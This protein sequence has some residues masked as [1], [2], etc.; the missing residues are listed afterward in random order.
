MSQMSSSRR[1][2]HR[3]SRISLRVD[4]TTDGV[5][6][7][8]AEIEN[9]TLSA[10]M[11]DAAYTRATKVVQEQQGIALTAREF[12]RVLDDLDRPAEVVLPLVRLAERIS[13]EDA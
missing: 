8:A 1:T 11:L 10:F 4:P 12:D 6:R 3:T 7:S 2:P 9:K 13:K 5:L